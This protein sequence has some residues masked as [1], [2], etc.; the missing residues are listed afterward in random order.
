MARGLEGLEL[1][2]QADTVALHAVIGDAIALGLQPFGERLIAAER[3][4]DDETVEFR[5]DCGRQ[6]FD[7]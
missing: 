6:N 4:V 1:P 3:T 2:A 5:R 7:F